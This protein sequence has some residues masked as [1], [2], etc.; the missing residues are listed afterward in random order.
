MLNRADIK[1]L[2]V[3]CAAIAKDHKFFGASV[4]SAIRVAALN[5]VLYKSRKLSESFSEVKRKS[6]FGNVR[7]MLQEICNIFKL[8]TCKR[9]GTVIRVNSFSMLHNKKTDHIFKNEN[10]QTVYGELLRGHKTVIVI[11]KNIKEFPGSFGRDRHIHIDGFMQS[12][13]TKIMA[14][15][16]GDKTKEIAL[17]LGN[18]IGVPA[19]TVMRQILLCKSTVLLWLVIFRVIKPSEVIYEA[20]HGSFEGEIIAAKILGIRT[21]EIF[22]GIV[23]NE[24]LSYSLKKKFYIGSITAVCERYI[25]PSNSQKKL[26]IRMTDA[27]ETI[28]T[29]KYSDENI[30]ERS[31]RLKIANKSKIYKKN[32]LLLVTINDKSIQLV[33]KFLINCKNQS[34]KRRS[35]VLRLHPHD[36]LQRW[37]AIIRRFRSVK[38][39]T[40]KSLTKDV[41][42]A[43]EVYAVDSTVA[44]QIR[45]MGVKYR[46]LE[47]RSWI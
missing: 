26:I 33:K 45:K 25:C 6:W 29:V 3:S 2:D 41:L 36:E 38:F 22:H 47:K 32:I 1:I 17:Q 11:V 16:T 39:S 7:T 9:N 14:C 24:E 4:W 19:A 30:V 34:M 12:A 10:L 15:I 35:I 13:A 31:E 5:E 27:Y 37:S 44:M 42:R 23:S 18:R 8:I 20:P 21:T 40:N 28:K 46:S 43:G